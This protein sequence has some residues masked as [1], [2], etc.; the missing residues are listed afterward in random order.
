MKKFAA[1][2]TAIALFFGG[3]ALASPASAATSTGVRDDKL[4]VQLVTKE[5]PSLKGI[6]RATMVK[7]AKSTCKYLR[8]GFTI[9]DAV[10][11]MQDNGFTENES[12]AFIAGAVVFY[13]PDQENNF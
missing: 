10:E 12:M 6:P 2:F 3:V 9:L 8:A 1:V 5:A 11:L 4:F 13:C 7:T